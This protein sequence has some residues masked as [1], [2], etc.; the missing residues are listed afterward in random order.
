MGQSLSG[1]ILVGDD[2]TL[3]LN[4]TEGSSFE[5]AIGGEITNAKGESVS[6][7][8]GEVTV[9][10]DDTSTWTLTGD[11]WITALEGDVANVIANGHTLYVN[12]EVALQ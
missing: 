11:T 9:A 6:S 12:G 10:L 7:E 1:T 5:G 8:V 3:T 4:L 2:S